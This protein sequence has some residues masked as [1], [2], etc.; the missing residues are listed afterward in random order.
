MEG[1]ASPRQLR[2]VVGESVRRVREAAGLR[3]DDVAIAARRHGLAWSRGRVATL[4]QGNKSIN[5]EELTILPSVLTDACGR[6]VG[7]EELIGADIPIALT[8]TVAV[9][10]RTLT[11]TLGGRPPRQPFAMAAADESSSPARSALDGWLR[12]AGETEAHAAR[13]LG[14]PIAEIVTG[15][16]ALWG[17]GF[18]QQRDVAAAALYHEDVSPDRRRALR[19]QVTRRL[20]GELDVFIERATEAFAE[21]RHG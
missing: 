11:A 10:S 14:R 9:D 18:A 19:G 21:S 15:S 6:P 20:L 2:V 7:I 4:E 5:A 17:R 12:A 13:R 16:H 8:S 3:Q 1:K